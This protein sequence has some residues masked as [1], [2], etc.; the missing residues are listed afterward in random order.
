[1]T[2]LTINHLHKTTPDPTAPLIFKIRHVLSKFTTLYQI[3]IL[4]LPGT[5]PASGALAEKLL[6]DGREF[7]HILILQFDW[8]T[9][10]PESSGR[11]LF[12]LSKMNF[13]IM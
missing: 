8:A 5:T 3:W 11:S 13:L 2:R 10:P 1:M 4:T 9:Q 12:S 6:E 7:Y